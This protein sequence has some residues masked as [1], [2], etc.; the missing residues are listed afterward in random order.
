ME[1]IDIGGSG[2]LSSTRQH[3]YRRASAF[4]LVFSAASR[5]SFNSI[6]R[7][8]SEINHHRQQGYPVVLVGTKTDLGEEVSPKEGLRRARELGA[9]YFHL[10]V[11]NSP[12]AE[13]PFVYLARRLMASS[14]GEVEL[15]RKKITDH[16]LPSA[17]NEKAAIGKSLFEWAKFALGPCTGLRQRKT[18]IGYNDKGR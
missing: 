5:S 15:S 14:A 17:G 12:Q 2:D 7:F 11:R 16:M 3:W 6:L 4:I 18:Q 8:Q 13:Q 9:E 10:S 1:V